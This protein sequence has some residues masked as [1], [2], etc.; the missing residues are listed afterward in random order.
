[1]TEHLNSISQMQVSQEL[2]KNCQE[3][4]IVRKH[5]SALF[6]NCDSLPKQVIQGH[7]TVLWLV[8]YV[9][10]SLE[11]PLCYATPNLL[12]FPAFEVWL[13]PYT[14]YITISLK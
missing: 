6:G 5:C 2:I 3:H 4:I 12:V 1:M 8:L 7:P 11:E 10:P 13:M 14:S 9:F